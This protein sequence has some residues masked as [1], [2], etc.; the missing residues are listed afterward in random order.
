MTGKEVPVMIL[1]G[2]TSC[3]HIYKYVQLA[4][5]YFGG[6]PKYKHQWVETR[7]D[8]GKLVDYG[9]ELVRTD[10]RDGACLY[11]KLDVSSAK[12]IGHD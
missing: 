7:E 12:L 9:W 11:R 6:S 5:T 10:S 1:L 8:E 3:N 4:H 2:H